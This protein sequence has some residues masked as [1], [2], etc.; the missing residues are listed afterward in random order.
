MADGACNLTE[1]QYEANL[2]WARNSYAQAFLGKQVTC[3]GC[4]RDFKLVQLFRCFH[5]G[6]Y[7]CR[8]CARV[9]FGDR[10]SAFPVKAEP[11]VMVVCRDYGCGYR[12]DCP[13]GEPHLEMDECHGFN[14][15]TPGRQARCEPLEVLA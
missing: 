1:E 12:R 7:F 11:P 13:H 9:H 4:E 15:I 3:R 14:C 2:I 6:S 10:P 5:C 8:K